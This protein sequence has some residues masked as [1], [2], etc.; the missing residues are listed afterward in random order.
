MLPGVVVS[1]E[2]VGY[3]LIFQH[4]WFVCFEPDVVILRGV[5][6]VLRVVTFRE[7]CCNI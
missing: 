6:V 2:I 1:V 7:T 5:D 4:S 3:V